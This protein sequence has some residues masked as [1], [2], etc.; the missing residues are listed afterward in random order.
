MEAKTKKEK[1]KYCG[2]DREDLLHHFIYGTVCT[3]CDEEFVQWLNKIAIKKRRSIK[4]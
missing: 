4:T 3:R 1:C 2:C